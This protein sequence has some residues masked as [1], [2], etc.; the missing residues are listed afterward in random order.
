VGFALVPELRGVPFFVMLSDL[1]VGKVGCRLVRQLSR[2][3]HL[4]CAE[5]EQMRFHSHAVDSWEAVAPR[6][7]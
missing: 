4:G 6:L 5:L 2:H 1:Q 7:P 3:F